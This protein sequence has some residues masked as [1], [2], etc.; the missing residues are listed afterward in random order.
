MSNSINPTKVQDTLEIFSGLHVYTSILS[1]YQPHTTT[2]LN[3]R[4]ILW[5]TDFILHVLSI[6]NNN[7]VHS[8][9]H[10]QITRFFE[11]HANST[12]RYGELL[13]CIAK[14]KIN[15]MEFF[16]LFALATAVEDEEL[17]SQCVLFDSLLENTYWYRSSTN[18][19]DVITNTVSLLMCMQSFFL[20]Y[21]KL[22]KNRM[23]YMLMEYIYCIFKHQTGTILHND[24]F[25][26][27]CKTRC[28]VFLSTVEESRDG[29]LIEKM[30]DVC[31]RLLPLC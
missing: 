3:R 31:S 20:E 14:T 24:A 11:H 2:N 16:T 15:Y 22:I 29:Y 12:G 4:T 21:N 9:L 23:I 8:L 26:D 17:S 5:T 6:T 25:K 1:A 19:K 30:K 18:E 28:E 7:A 10:Y 13:H 27:V